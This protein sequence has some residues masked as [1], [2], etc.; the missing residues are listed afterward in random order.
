ME[1]KT[2]LLNS[3]TPH[4]AH[5][6]GNI[7]Q[8]HNATNGTLDNLMNPLVNATGSAKNPCDIWIAGVILGLIFAFFFAIVAIDMRAKYR[9]GELRDDMLGIKNV[10]VL[11]L[12]AVPM[13]LVAL[14]SKIRSLVSRKQAVPAEADGEA[15]AQKTRESQVIV[16]RLAAKSES[17]GTNS[18]VSSA[19]IAPVSV[20]PG[21]VAPASVAPVSRAPVSRAPVSVGRSHVSTVH[22]DS[23]GGGSF[24]GGSF[25]GH[26][27]SSSSSSSSNG[28]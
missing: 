21:S 6:L 26:N 27:R 24:G 28:S 14:F 2:D 8:K 16:Q 25:G 13:L 7:T 18:S 17:E 9:T 23:F 19:D 5:H 15:A 11:V 12:K 20:A 10:L 4:H 22:D 3:S 1:N